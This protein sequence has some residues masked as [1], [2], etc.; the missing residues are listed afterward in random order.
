MRNE[1]REGALPDPFNVRL[2]PRRLMISP[3][4]VGCKPMLCRPSTVSHD[5]QN[6]CCSTTSTDAALP[7]VAPIF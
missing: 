1:R 7:E 2:Q 3:G 4:A 5:I 6:R